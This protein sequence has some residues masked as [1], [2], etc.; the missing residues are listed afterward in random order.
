MRPISSK[1]TA[2]HK[3]V[4]PVLYFALLLC[5]GE[6]MASDGRFGAW[7][8]LAPSALAVAGIVYMRRIT[9]R[10]ADE[11]FDDGDALVIRRKSRE[12]RVLLANV[13]AVQYSFVTGPPR[14]TVTF[15]TPAVP[16]ARV[17][18]VPRVVPGMLVFRQPPLVADLRKR[19]GSR[20]PSTK[21]RE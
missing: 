1:L 21:I 11:V 2:W 5:A 17:Q 12:L 20:P 13:T 8:V 19:A 14:V 10:L 15:A 4:V 18:F 6:W 9:F 3:R 16:S 7:A